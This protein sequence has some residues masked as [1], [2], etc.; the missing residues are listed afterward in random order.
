MCLFKSPGTSEYV[1]R[2][3]FFPDLSF[4][5]SSPSG[6]VC[7]FV[8]VI[9]P[10][11]VPTLILRFFRND[12]VPLS[13]FTIPHCT[14]DFIPLI[15]NETT[16]MAMVRRATAPQETTK[17]KMATGDSDNDNGDSATGNGATGDND[18]D[19]WHRQGQRKQ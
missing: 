8:V 4:L 10:T 9:S 5:C 2:G 13:L 17:T 11:T 7:C 18:D 3:I 6:A 16:T 14:Y 12:R 19:D 1:V 15:N